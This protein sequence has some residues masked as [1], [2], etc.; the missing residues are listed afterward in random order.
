MASMGANLLISTGQLNPRSLQGQVAIVTGAG[1]GIGYEAARALAWLGARVII[2]EIDRKTG[3]PAAK[4]I[5]QEMG[6]SVAAF[7]QTDAGDDASITRLARKAFK[8]YGKVD[9]VLN[10]ATITPMGLVKDRSIKDWDA[11]Y[12]VNLRGPVLLAQAFLPGMLARNYGVFVCVSS[13]GGAYMGAYEVLKTAQ[14]DLARTLDAELEGTGVIAFSIGPGISRTPGAEAQMEAIARYYGKSVEEFYQTYQE[15]MISPEAAGA[16]FAAAVALAE[17]FK[18]QDIG[19]RQALIAA[20]IDIDAG[21]ITAAQRMWTRSEIS[22]ALDL[23]RAALK[24]LKEQSDGWAQRPLF[25]RQ[26]VARDFKRNAGMPAEDWLAALERLKEALKSG[27]AQA[28]SAGSPPVEH[29]AAYYRH[30]Q[31]TA[32]GYIKDADELDKGLAA[33]Q[34]WID[35]A[36][37]LATLLQG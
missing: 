31:E 2:A 24:T 32:R 15:H 1:R 14:V 22:Q 10:N 8:R 18:G 25:E 9:I 37:G 27:D 35:E 20:G 26:W 12:R 34:G 3:E 6:D 17:R 19:A 16:G 4:A 23:C 5:N 13:V 29:L 36:Q 7:I 28:I 33:L 21:K 11:S 30:Q